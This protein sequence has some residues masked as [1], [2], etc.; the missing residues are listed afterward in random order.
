MVEV[1]QDTVDKAELFTYFD[2]AVRCKCGRLRKRGM[3]C[4]FCGS[5][6]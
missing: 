1:S 3:S 6:D 2:I 4:I 5:V